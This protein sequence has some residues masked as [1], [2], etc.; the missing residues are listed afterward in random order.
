[1]TLLSLSGI[2]IAQIT[3][4]LIL[5]LLV[6]GKKKLHYIWACFNAAVCVWGIGCS[7]IG[8]A[9]TIDLA[10]L[11]WQIGLIGG[12][13]LGVFI[14]HTSYNLTQSHRKGLLT[15]VYLQGIFFSIAVLKFPLLV[16]FKIMFDQYYYPIANAWYSAMFFSWLAVVLFAHYDMFR[17]IKVASSV[18]KRNIR[19]FL[20]AL[21]PGFCG[22]ASVPL[23]AFNVG[24]PPVMNFGIV[25][26]VLLVTYGILRYQL[27]QQRER[28]AML[29][30]ASKMATIGIMTSSLNHEVRNPL[31]VAKGVLQSYLERKR[32]SQSSNQVIASDSEAISEAGIAT[33][34]PEADPRN[35]VEMLEDIA[36][37]VELATK[38]IDR[39]TEIMRR[40]STFSKPG[41]RKLESVNIAHAVDEVLF[42]L[43]YELKLNEI[44]ITKDIDPQLP[45][46]QAD[47][48]AIEEIL[49]NLLMN[50]F[51]ALEGRQNGEITI[52]ATTV[53]RPQSAVHGQLTVDRGRNGDSI[54]ITISDTG[55]GIAKD[56]Q[57]KIFEPFYTTKGPERG[58]GLGLFVTKQLVEGLNGK[59]T[60]TSEAGQ[61]TMFK[62]IFNRET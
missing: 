37:T 24:I 48:R 8:Q 55:P 6:F 60:V 36:K 18:Q 4:V 58:T 23:S 33:S 62:I 57:E 1:M 14:Y 28:D 54:E 56:K 21:L 53:H 51:H 27:E 2:S 35:D 20:I 29:A 39:A 13:W 5:I 3:A 10:R 34:P 46:L 31:Y 43:E 45:T 9:N 52:R 30:Q 42:L 12:L 25:I 38:Q 22:G 26:Y 15:L 44:K 61:G 49:F 47:Q 16:D 41:E 32:R 17:Y 50:A 40:L 59:I 19:L 7:I 11:G